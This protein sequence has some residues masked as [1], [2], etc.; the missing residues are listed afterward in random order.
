MKKTVIDKLH[1]HLASEMSKVNSLMRERMQSDKVELIGNIAEHLINSGGKRIRPILT[2]SSAK[3][4]N[5]TG[6]KHIKL[7]AT[8]EFIHNATLLHDDVVDRSERRRD[9]KTANSIWDNKSSILV[10]DFLFSRS[11]KLM[12]ETNSSKILGILAT[13]SGMISEGEVLQLSVSKDLRTTTSTYYEVIRG[14]T[15]ALFSAACETGAYVG[16]ASKKQVEALHK[17]G[18]ALGICF[19]IIDD[20]LDYKGKNPS[21]GKNTGN[22]F[23]ERKV[24]LPLII[25]YSKA[26]KEEKK[27]WK[28]TIGKGEQ[29]PG[30]FEKA[31]DILNSRGTLEATYKVALYWS[32]LAKENLRKIPKSVTRDLMEELCDYVISRVS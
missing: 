20:L 26:S 9:K 5:Y 12:I 3:L 10:G 4:F 27:F 13:A 11:F 21:L 15:A 30:D 16:G 29:K 23:K 6:T 22:D 24:T 25:A 32:N 8:V 19:Q 17:F 1:T 7:A 18:D 28:R 31:L 14:K 2:I